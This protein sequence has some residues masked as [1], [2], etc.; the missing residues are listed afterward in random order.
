MSSEELLKVTLKLLCKII[1]P[2]LIASNFTKQN[3]VELG[4]MGKNQTD[5]NLKQGWQE[6][7][8]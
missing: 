1:T 2:V 6:T 5:S 3:L 4:E 8:C 7:F